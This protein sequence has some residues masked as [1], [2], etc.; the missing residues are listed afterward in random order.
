MSRKKLIVIVNRSY[1]DSPTGYY[2]ASFRSYL[3]TYGKNTYDVQ[4]VSRENK[5]HQ[6]TQSSNIT[7]LIDSVSTSY[8]LIKKARR[9]RADYHIIM[10]DP[11]FNNLFA[12]LLLDP[13]RTALWSMDIYPS[14]F[15]AKGLLKK[16]SSWLK[17]YRNI[18]RRK[19]PS[20]LI[21]LGPQQTSYLR[22]QYYTENTQFIE[23]P[24][25][26]KDININKQ[27][28]SI[29]NWYNERYIYFAY[30]GNMGEAHDVEFLNK[31]IEQMDAEKQRIVIR[32]SG[33]KKYLINTSDMTKVICPDEH[34]PYDDMKYIDAQIV[35]LLPKWTHVCVPSKA[36][37]AVE[38][39]N[40]IVYCGDKSSDTWQ[41][42]KDCSWYVDPNYSAKDISKV[43]SEITK[44][45]VSIKKQK[46]QSLR[47]ALRMN[48]FKGY[49]KILTEIEKATHE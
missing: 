34:I 4:V 16:N 9:L 37:T 48:H 26:L 36:L 44:E 42:V 33:A 32:A 15:V 41:Y 12:A 43:M 17:L 47:D 13:H 28:K 21:S 11:G 22:E 31:W 39:G 5:Y 7:K 1:P 3:L 23:V 45:N 25:G 10:S 20:W 2:A 29:P 18:I 49:Q 38:I 14:A 24:I 19:S 46:T 6:K 30:I 8:T 35:S 40:T 27:I